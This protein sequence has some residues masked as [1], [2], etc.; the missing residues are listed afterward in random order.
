MTMIDQ[1][2]LYPN[3]PEDEY[4]AD[5]LCAEP[6]LS[7]SIAQLLVTR[8]PIHAAAAHPRITRYREDK[9]SDTFDFA[10]AAHALLLEADKERA[11]AA[12]KIPLLVGQWER[13]R[14]MVEVVREQMEEIDQL[15]GVLAMRDAYRELTVVW[16]EPGGVW[17]RCRPDLMLNVGRVI[18]FKF[19]GT[20]ATPDVWASKTAWQMLYDFRAEFYLRGMRAVMP[21]RNWRYQFVVV[22][23]QPPYALALFEPPPQAYEEVAPAVQ[24]AIDLWAECRRT[25]SWPG[26]SREIQW[27]EP[28]KWTGV[29]WEILS[30]QARY[31]TR[32]EIEAAAAYAPPP[33]ID[34]PNLHRFEV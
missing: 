17:C 1:P 27:M 3:I 24:D 12:G 23:N 9:E 6:S 2:G 5:E 25:N 18:D 33:H 28:P 7:C 34:H 31:T 13:A 32:R 29:R 16:Q 22:E 26:Y 30:H 15:R 21:G 19:T 8:S 20:A 4:H 10:K 14:L 11:R